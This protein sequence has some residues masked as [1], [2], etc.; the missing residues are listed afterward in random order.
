M[1]ALQTPTVISSNIPKLDEIDMDSLKSPLN[2][3]EL[4]WA[5][6][7]AQTQKSCDLDWIYL[8]L[9]KTFFLQFQLSHIG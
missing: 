2:S 3:E 5:V 9:F 4:T 8:L 7:E 1:E 6:E